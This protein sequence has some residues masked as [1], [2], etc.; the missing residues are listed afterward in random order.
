MK[1]FLFKGFSKILLLMIVIYLSIPFEKLIRTYIFKL[2]EATGE[3][4]TA[5]ISG[6]FVVISIYLLLLITSKYLTSSKIK[7]VVEGGT[8]LEITRYIFFSLLA[9]LLCGI[10]IAV[11]K[12]GLVYILNNYFGFALR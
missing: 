9:L 12:E 10:L 5:I 3:G 6:L 11:A 2:V 4:V 7:Q 1:R 8:Y